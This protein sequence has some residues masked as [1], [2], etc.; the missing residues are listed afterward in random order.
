[1][2][3]LSRLWNAGR[4]GCEGQTRTWWWCHGP[5]RGRWIAGVEPEHWLKCKFLLTLWHVLH[6]T[7]HFS[8]VNCSKSYGTQSSSCFW[9][10]FSFARLQAIQLVRYFYQ[11]ILCCFSCV[12]CIWW[13]VKRPSHL[14]TWALTR[15]M[16]T[17]FYFPLVMPNPI[18]QQDS[19]S[20]VPGE[21]PLQ[22]AL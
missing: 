20:K 11:E 8:P 22:W 2:L 17:S 6:D 18:S 10:P 1:M 13:C 7:F 5:G 3:A 15:P 19:S 21:D 14:S 12:G 4:W 16:K 9:Y